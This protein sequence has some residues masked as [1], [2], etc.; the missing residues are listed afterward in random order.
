MKKPIV[1]PFSGACLSGKTTTMFFLKE[2]LEQV[3]YTVRIIKEPI[4]DIL[5]YLNLSID[6]LRNDFSTFVKVQK[7]VILNRK[8]FEIDMALVYEEDFVFI[9]RSAADSFFYITYYPNKQNLTEDQLK[10]YEELLNMTI[11]YVKESKYEILLNF[12]PLDNILEK[13][14]NEYRP[15]NISQTK[16]IEYEMISFYNKV[17]FSNM[18]L[19]VNLN[20]LSTL[21]E[22]KGII[23]DLRKFVNEAEETKNSIE[24]EI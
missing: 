23:V 9:D 8:T 4:R 11:E 16:Q 20:N 3:G 19:D 17:F 18:Y 10:L 7:E 22:L 21:E 24:N 15:Q 13:D 12:R 14:I 6:D 1:I 5:D 2:Y